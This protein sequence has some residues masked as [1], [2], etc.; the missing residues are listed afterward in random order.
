MEIKS[1]K[2]KKQMLVG[3]ERENNNIKPGG[4]IYSSSISAIPFL[5]A[6]FLELKNTL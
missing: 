6:Q 3:I 5:M 1:E 2:K 4:C